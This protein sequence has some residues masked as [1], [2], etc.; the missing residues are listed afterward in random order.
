VED[1][2]NETIMVLWDMFHALYLVEEEEVEEE[3]YVQIDY[4]P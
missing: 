4:N 1:Q 2:P 3:R